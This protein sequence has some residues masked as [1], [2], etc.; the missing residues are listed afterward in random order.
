MTLTLSTADSLR[1][2][3]PPRLVSTGRG[4]HVGCSHVGWSA[5]ILCFA[6]AFPQAAEAQR[7]SRAVP[8]DDHFLVVAAMH[9]GEFREAGDAFRDVAAGGIRSTEGRW[10]DSIAYHA[11]LGE[12][13]YH[14]GDLAL[15]L[16]QYNAA[17]RLFLAHSDWMLR[18]EFP[19][20]EPE[21]VDRASKITWGRPSR[22]VSMGRFP[23]TLLSQQGRFDNEN[24]LRRG[25]V[26]ANPELRAIR[27]NEIAYCTGLAIRRRRELMGATCPHDPLTQAVIEALARRPAPPN[28]WGQSWVSVLLGLAYS[29]AGQTQQAIGELQRGLLAGG[30][31]DHP[32]TAVALLEMGRLAMERGQHEAAATFFYEATF[33]AVAF[34]QP[35][36]VEEAF[37]LG[38][39]NFLATTHQGTYAP[40]PAAIEFAKSRDV[41]RYAHASLLIALADNFTAR[42]DAARAARLLAEAQQTMRRSD[43]V[44]ADVGARYYHQLA[45]VSYQQANLAAGDAALA[46]MLA[47]Q[48]KGSK[49]LFQIGLADKLYL[50]GRVSPRVAENLFVDLLREPTGKDWTADLRETLSV[51]L[52]PHLLPMEHWFEI[53]LERKDFERAI[54]ITDIVRRHRFYSSL[55][56]G[57]RLL[58]L[59]WIMEA[60]EASL[61]ADAILQRQDLM[62]R[63]PN[64][65]ALSRQ[66]AAVR[67][68]LESL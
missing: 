26:I 21:Q 3:N 25:G 9:A 36:I 28:S 62:N 52:T 63:Y 67:A 11:R 68:E 56:M 35:D 30:T 37:R 60:P 50:A 49:W 12:C 24:V 38:S 34:S 1:G 23:E 58:T 51:T 16:E 64:Y 33:P 27:A 54:E 39:D 42:G 14:L 53:T 65:A 66:G 59:R 44:G 55:P 17:A 20:I 46:T 57:G 8:G 7:G 40:L 4:S 2:T 61:P 29:S 45:L 47:W 13:Y 48:R 41:Y 15:A 19:A 31:F 32:L 18:V 6:L 10:I 22:P 5:A 43:M